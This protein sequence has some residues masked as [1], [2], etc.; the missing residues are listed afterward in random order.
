MLSNVGVGEIRGAAG[1][2]K[3]EAKELLAGPSRFLTQRPKSNLGA[4]G[5]NS[6][7]HVKGHCG[8]KTDKQ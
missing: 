6:Y 5:E 1:G 3:K 7:R 8:I 4:S 2:L